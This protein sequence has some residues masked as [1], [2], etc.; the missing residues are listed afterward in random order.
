MSLPRNDPR[1]PR[2]ARSAWQVATVLLY[3][4]IAVEM[5]LMSRLVDPRTGDASMYLDLAKN[6]RAGQGMVERNADGVFE[7]NLL[8]PPGYPAF[9]A[10]CQA[11]F[12]EGSSGILAVQCLLVLATLEAYRRSVA[13]R[14]GVEGGVVFLAAAAAVP[15]VP[16]LAL[17][18]TSET[19]AMALVA[20]AFALLDQP[21]PSARRGFLAGV[22][23]GLASLARQHL[24]LGGVALALRGALDRRRPAVLRSLAL[25]AGLAVP[26][27]PWA[28]R[29]ARVGGV[30]SPVSGYA[31]QFRYT[32]YMETAFDL[33]EYDSLA[34]GK[35]WTGRLA[36]CG[37]P[38]RL[39]Q[40]NRELGVPE[41]A[42]T[43][44]F[45]TAES[46]FTGIRRRQEACHLIN[47]ATRSYYEQL[48]AA[49]ILAWRLGYFMP[50]AW[51]T[52]PSSYPTRIPAWARWAASGVQAGLF[53]L[54]LARIAWLFRLRF[55][56]LAALLLVCGALVVASLTPGLAAACLLLAW[57]AHRAGATDLPPRGDPW[58][59]DVA[60][61]I[62]SLAALMAGRHVEARYTAVI[63]PAAWAL[64]AVGVVE[65][66][67]A[68]RSHAVA[69]GRWDQ[70][71]GGDG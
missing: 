61:F 5:L 4:F 1:K 11:A 55:L 59:V 14:A 18:V 50:K 51:I 29:N 28:W 36:T 70:G 69:P 24:A 42:N 58:Q 27:L 49:R 48:G 60:L 37:L 13:R 20:L 64:A 19:P 63:Q 33:R 6:L 34:G 65:A 7:P 71:R 17:R 3:V 22:A 35:G 66:V 68:V 47:E 67:R 9:L 12:G 44:G 23:L 25:A 45:Y 52:N 39:R 56:A 43:F 40:I 32:Y 2:T 62:L 16:E 38:E 8:R 21:R 30:F 54:A 53:L 15:S 57:F 31:E 26:L 41:E 46:P 10:A